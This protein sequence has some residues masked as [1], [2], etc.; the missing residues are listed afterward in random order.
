MFDLF[1]QE[2]GCYQDVKFDFDKE[3]PVGGVDG[4]YSDESAEHR[5]VCEVLRQGGGKVV[6]AKEDDDN[7][8]DCTGDPKCGV[9]TDES[10]DGEFTETSA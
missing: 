4:F 2:D 8:C 10:R 7:K 5:H 1:E 9:E 3:R 6:A